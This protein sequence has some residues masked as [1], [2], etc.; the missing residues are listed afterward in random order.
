MAET[1]GTFARK[2]FISSPG[3]MDAERSIVLEE[4]ARLSRQVRK[5]GD[6]SLVVVRWPD[7]IGAGAAEYGQSVI[8]RQTADLDILVCLMGTRMGTPTPRANGG[9]EEEFDRAIEDR[10]TGSRVQVL[11]FFSNL[12]VRPQELD[13]YQ[14]MLVRAF[15][16]KA[17]RLGVLYHTFDDHEE[18]RRRVRVSL[19][20]AHEVICNRS[21]QDA[22]PSQAPT[23]AGTTKAVRLG[24][25]L[26][27]KQITGPQW[28]DSFLVPLAEYRRRNCRLTGQLKTASPYFRFGFKYYDSRE[29]LFSAGSIQTPGANILVHVGK[30]DD[31]PEW[32]ITAY[33]AGYRT[34]PDSV[35][36]WT[37][38]LT[39]AR[40]EIDISTAGRVALK[41]ED[42]LVYEVFFPLDGVPNLALLAWGDEHDFRCEVE[43]LLLEVMQ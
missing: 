4:V 37:T 27:K 7:D 40:F 15:R 14:L 16:E 32:F 10:L 17:A 28:A 29:P 23:G 19:R 21:V 5:K 42:D 11:L 3:G 8:N 9:T 38:G 20:D 31:G 1:E 2:V 39:S 36:V 18:L 34:G 30:N 12:A 43:G 25:L 6:P 35:L 26:L 13:P 24:N 22:V 33:R 41:L